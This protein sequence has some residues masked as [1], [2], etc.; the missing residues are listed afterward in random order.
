MLVRFL[1]DCDGSEVVMEI[2]SIIFNHNK[3]GE[4]GDTV[5]GKIILT[6]ADGFVWEKVKEL[7]YF[8]YKGIANA[9]F[10]QG[11]YDFVSGSHDRFRLIDDE[12]E[13]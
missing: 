1:D 12:E 5:L 9:L 11:R 3:G 10:F 8:E 7:H 13:E 4:I 6:T 2:N